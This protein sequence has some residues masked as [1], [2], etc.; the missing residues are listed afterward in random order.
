MT[1]GGRKARVEES[2]VAGRMMGPLIEIKQEE[3]KI[4]I[5]ILDIL[6]FRS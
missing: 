2:R 1:G 5:F 4:I 6:S 3:R